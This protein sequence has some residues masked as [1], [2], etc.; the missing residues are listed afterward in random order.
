M[1]LR[2][3]AV[4][5]FLAG[6]APGTVQSQIAETQHLDAEIAFLEARAARDEADPITPTRLGHAYLR[7]ARQ[8]G[9]FALYRRAEAAFEQALARV[10]DHFGA[11]TGLGTARAASHRFREALEIGERAIALSPETSDGYAVAGDAALELGLLDKA[12]EMYAAVARL[13]PGYYADTRLANLAAARGQAREAYAALERAQSDA[14][15]REL[16][17][18]LHAWCFVRA[19]SIAFDIGDW[20]RAERSYTT[21]LRLTPESAAA[22]EHLAELRAAQGRRREAL[23]LYAKAIDASPQP[24]FHE[25][26]GHVHRAAGRRDEAAQAFARARQGYIA[27]AEAG[28]PGAFRPLALFYADVERNPAAALVWAGKDLER[29][30]DAVTLGVLA[31]TL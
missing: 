10:P 20:L 11:L 9:E 30:Q 26:V 29:R 8:T 28:D 16:P 14:A 19:G 23:A 31:W 22:L 21:A 5:V 13:A 18:E 6:A 17:A 15:R 27:A 7:Q 2:T 3:L 12:A 25:A 4:L 24:E 1:L